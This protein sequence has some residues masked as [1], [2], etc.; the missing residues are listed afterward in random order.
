[1]REREREDLWKVFQGNPGSLRN[2]KSLSL[3]FFQSSLLFTQ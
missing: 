1:M 2:I 3:L